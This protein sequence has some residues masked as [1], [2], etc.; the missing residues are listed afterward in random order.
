VGGPSL[1]KKWE[2]LDP[3]GPLGSTTYQPTQHLVLLDILF[4]LFQV[5]R[6]SIC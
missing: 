1:Q 2:S 3:C 4:E 5:K 6:G